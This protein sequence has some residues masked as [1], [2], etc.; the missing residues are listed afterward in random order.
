METK[1][2][3]LETFKDYEFIDETHTY[4]YKGEKVSI[5]T[6]GLIHQYSNEFDKWEMSANVARKRG[7]SQLEV[8]E[9]WR[10]ENLHSTIKG[11]MIHE[12]AQSLWEGK[13]YIFKYDN[14]PDEINIRR[15]QEELLVMSN[16]AV[17][18]YKDYKSVY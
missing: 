3:I 6:T 18:F 16:Q 13:D 2:K 9:E 5:S 7:I 4:Y 10:I 1:D 12:F 15:L 11:S 8:L 14:I 17:N